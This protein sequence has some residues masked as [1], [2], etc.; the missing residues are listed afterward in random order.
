MADKNGIFSQVDPGRKL[1][2]SGFN[3]SKRNMFDAFPG[4]LYPVYVDNMIP[5]DIK[6]LRLNWS[7]KANP[8][9][10]PI[11]TPVK[12]SFFAFF[13]PWAQIFG[14]EYGDSS[15]HFIQDILSGGKDGNNTDTIPLL[16]NARCFFDHDAN[17]VGLNGNNAV[18]G[19]SASL[20]YVCS[21]SNYFG[22]PTFR[23]TGKSA[24]TVVPAIKY[25]PTVTWHRAYWRIVRDYF[26][27]E[28]TQSDLMDEVFKD[29]S[30]SELDSHDGQ[31]TLNGYLPFPTLWSRDYFM[32]CLSD[33]LKGTPPALSLGSLTVPQGALSSHM[34]DFAGGH[35]GQLLANQT[36][37]S[38]FS[39]M[40]HN[41]TVT[42]EKEVAHLRV[43]AT[44]VTLPV[45]GSISVDDLR[46][47]FATQRI[48]ERANRCGS[49]YTE[50]LLS[51][52]GTAPADGSLRRPY[53]LGGIRSQIV[54]PEVLQTSQS[55]DTPQGNRAGVGFSIG[56][57][58]FP[59]Y[60][61]KEFGTFMVVCNIEPEASYCDG[62]SRE[63]TRK[64]RFDFFNPSY[65][66]LTE[67]VIKAGEIFAD[68]CGTVSGYDPSAPFGYQGIYNDMRTSFDQISGNFRYGELDTW[69]MAL[70]FTTKPALNARFQRIWTYKKDWMRPFAVQNMPPYLFD[71]NLDVRD[72]RPM[73]KFPVPGLIDHN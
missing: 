71:L 12:V 58:G 57:N 28:D 62:L 7:I 43:P 33:Y 59:T 30:G 52:F 23:V 53:Y 15:D 61:A 73:V 22:Y 17:G 69:H 29:G 18:T 41:G 72:I 19:S 65:Q 38:G 4:R 24:G 31:G 48:L 27:N 3:R 34:L 25:A 55:G 6:K 32:S 54:T 21:L 66:N 2:R 9:V 51:T 46:L 49:R 68:P 70:R 45:N 16:S 39:Y 37:S 11:N 44:P 42:A 56:R 20:A 64:S 67:D 5:G 26:I 40:T 50:Y 10:T 1:Y 13:V 63:A 8:S 60:H 14:E 36:S 35:E 47:A